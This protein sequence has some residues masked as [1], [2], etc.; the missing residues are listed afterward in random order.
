MLTILIPTISERRAMCDTLVRLLQRDIERGGYSG[1][2]EI[3]ICEDNK[4][5]SIGFKRNYLARQCKTEYCVM[6]DDDDMLSEHY[7]DKVLPL[8]TKGPDCVTYLE[9]IYSDG[10]HVQTAIHSNKLS[11]WENGVKLDKFVYDYGRTP[12]CKD[13]IKTS[14]VKEIGFKDMRFGEDADFAGRL[15]ISGLIKKEAHINEIMYIYHMPGAMT[16]AQH[17]KRYGVS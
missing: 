17:N 10:K 3:I 9:G 12:F 13:I 6:V 1:L 8:L 11:R 5:A 7:F 16:T 4:E 15:K 2:V 14:I